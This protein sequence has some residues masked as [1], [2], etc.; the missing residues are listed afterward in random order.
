MQALAATAGDDTGA[1]TVEHRCAQAARQR[2]TALVELSSLLV[3]QG[4]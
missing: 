1:A 4:T 2:Q 3:E